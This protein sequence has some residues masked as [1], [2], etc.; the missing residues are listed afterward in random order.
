[1]QSGPS[2]AAPPTVQEGGDVL[3]TVRSGA[4]QIYLLL[5]GERPVPLPV[6]GGR[7]EFRVPPRVGG[8]SIIV[9]SDL[10]LPKPASTTVL[11]VGNS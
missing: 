1:M 5:P 8:G 3:V 11:V 7:A 6:R 9:I 10:L 2:L 4:T